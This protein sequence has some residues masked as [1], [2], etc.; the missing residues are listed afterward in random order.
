MYEL[1]ILFFVVLHFK[2]YF[3][4]KELKLNE[5]EIDILAYFVM[6]RPEFHELVRKKDNKPMEFMLLEAWNE[7]QTAQATN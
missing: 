1:I 7:V 5:E 4:Q 6:E 2:F 3:L